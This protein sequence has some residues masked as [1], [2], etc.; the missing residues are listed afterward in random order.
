MCTMLSSFCLFCIEFDLLSTVQCH[1]RIIQGKCAVKCQM[2]QMCKVK[3]TS[4]KKVS[5]SRSIAM[6]VS[7]KENFQAAAQLLAAFVV[8][9]QAR[10]E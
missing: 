5:S 3:E 10:Q 1:G 7:L 2:C 8:V 9:R 6:D 4:F